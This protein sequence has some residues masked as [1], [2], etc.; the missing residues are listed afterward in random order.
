MWF[1]NKYHGVISHPYQKDFIAWRSTQPW[2]VALTDK[3]CSWQP[4]LDWQEKVY[5]K[6]PGRFHNKFMHREAPLVNLEWPCVV[7]RL[8]EPRERAIF[9]RL[10]RPVVLFADGDSNWGQLST[11]FHNR[12]VE[13]GVFDHNIMNH[14]CYP[15]RR[16][17]NGSLSRPWCEPGDIKRLLDDPRVLG[18]FHLGHT[19]ITHRKLYNVPLATDFDEMFRRYKYRNESM[20]APLAE[21]RPR[22]RLLENAN[23]GW[24]PRN[25]TNAMLMRNLGLPNVLTHGTFRDFQ[26]RLLETKM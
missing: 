22:P 16:F 24:G 8:L 18:L 11:T 19:N 5:R 4:V 20:L 17:A 10:K 13:W 3:N 15:A 2:S 26:K 9:E 21:R 14:D 23:S 25:F 7:H 12:T 1:N 6:P